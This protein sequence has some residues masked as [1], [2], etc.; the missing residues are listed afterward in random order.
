MPFLLFISSVFISE[1]NCNLGNIATCIF[2][3]KLASLA[4]TK[5]CSSSNDF[6]VFKH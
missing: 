1:V 3:N 6:E 4:S 5:C 2:K